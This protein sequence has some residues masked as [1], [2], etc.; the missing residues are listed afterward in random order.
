MA[1]RA[2][3]SDLRWIRSVCPLV[4]A[5]LFAASCANWSQE[6]ARDGPFELELADGTWPAERISL[7]VPLRH[8]DPEGPK[9]LIRLVRVFGKQ[10]KLAPFFFLAGG[11]GGSGTGKILRKNA[12]LTPLEMAILDHADIVFIDQRGTGAA[13]PRLI[14]KDD[15]QIPLVPAPDRGLMLAIGSRLAKGCKRLWHERGI[16]LQAFNTAESA[17]DLE[18]VRLALRLPRISLLGASYGS[19]L[20]FAYLRRFGTIVD[21]GVFSGIQ[22]PDHMYKLPQQIDALLETIDRRAP[23]A[24]GRSVA[25]LARQVLERLESAPVRV[26]IDGDTEI[27]LGPYDFQRFL[28]RATRRYDVHRHLPLA[29]AEMADGDFTELARRRLRT[30]TPDKRSLD[31]MHSAMKCASGSSQTRLQ[32]IAA[33]APH[34]IAGYTS[35]FPFPGTCH[36]WGVEPLSDGF[37]APFHSEVPMLLFSG[38]FDARTPA[39]NGQEMLQWFPKAH[40]AIVSKLGHAECYFQVCLDLVKELLTKG[41]VDRPRV[42]KISPTQEEIDRTFRRRRTAR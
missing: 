36:A 33:E 10:G 37:R 5:L 2:R 20:A 23:L 22:G 14:C 21:F 35:N 13:I 31:A 41:R 11:P 16:D 7:S 4:A 32:A 15:A 38:I 25:Q 18:A 26:R 39:S 19:H 17:Q 1:F 40:H 3:W 8:E 42:I 30:R 9:I 6:P 28:G 24:D 27:E 29:I 12:R 34:A